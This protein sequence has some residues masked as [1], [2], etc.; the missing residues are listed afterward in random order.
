LLGI[1]REG[2]NLL[3]GLMNIDQGLNKGNV[4]C[5]CKKIYIPQRQLFNIFSKKTVN[6]EKEKNLGNGKL[7]ELIISGDGFWKKRGF[8]S[9]FDLSS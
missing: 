3:C 9:L 1:G 4:W 8:S 5:N 7:A 6:E 2:L